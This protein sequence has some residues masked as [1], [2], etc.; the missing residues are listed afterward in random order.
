MIPVAVQTILSSI[1]RDTPSDVLA[2][3]MAWFDIDKE[4]EWITRNANLTWALMNGAYA[5][6]IAATKWKDCPYSRDSIWRWAWVTGY[7]LARRIDSAHA[8]IRELE[9]GG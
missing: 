7:D 3:L 2:E 1:G 5:A 4:P 6:E 9:A 8:R